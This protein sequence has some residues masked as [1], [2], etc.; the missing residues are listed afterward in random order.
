[1]APSMIN[2]APHSDRARTEGRSSLLSLSPLP[3]GGG[4]LL[5]LFQF[6]LSQGEGQQQ[7][8]LTGGHP[9][10]GPRRQVL[11]AK[12]PKQQV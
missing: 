12:Q 9:V 3:L 10:D 6:D 8:L 5:S 11:I 4:L 2:A 7:V 1:M